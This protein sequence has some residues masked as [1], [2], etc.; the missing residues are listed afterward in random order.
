MREQSSFT[1]SPRCAKTLCE[2]LRLSCNFIVSLLRFLISFD[3]QLFSNKGGFKGMAE[4]EGRMSKR[5]TEKTF[6]FPAA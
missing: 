2:I 5:Q 3:F 6:H 1:Q 4:G